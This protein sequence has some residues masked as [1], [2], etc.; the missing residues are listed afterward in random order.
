MRNVR[1]QADFD[2]AQNDISLKPFDKQEF[3]DR[4]RADLRQKRNNP[5][6]GDNS[7]RDDRKEL[8][9]EFQG[10][11]QIDRVH[12][13]LSQI[14]VS[15]QQIKGGIHL[16]QTGLHKLAAKLGV[17]PEDVKLYLNSLV[18]QLRD[19][20]EAEAETL[21]EAYYAL[22]EAGQSGR[23]FEGQN[24]SYEPDAL[25]SVTIRDNL[26]GKAKFIQGTQAN[27]LMAQ[28]KTPGAN[29][30][31]ILAPLME[32]ESDDFD[33]EIKADS[34]TYN[35]MWR[36]GTRHGMGTAM[37]K[38]NG[39]PPITLVDVRDDQG[40]EINLS[41]PL[42]KEFLRQARDFLGRE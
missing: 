3:S 19:A 10:Q 1:E 34:G 4:G 12:E 28:L 29:E 38:A 41:P 22:I 17:G 5:R 21:T 27:Q 2:V 40:N 6:Y 35:F 8:L 9:D 23:P 15:D 26:S 20:D 16:T 33:D 24:Y 13:I 36:L 18:Q 11:P 39:T 42:H 14:G 7:L 32:A 37:F 31:A 25:G 30:D